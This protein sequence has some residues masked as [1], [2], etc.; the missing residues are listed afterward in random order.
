MKKNILLILFFVSVFSA[1]GQKLTTK[2][3]NILKTAALTVDNKN[4]NNRV[5]KWV[6]PI[7]YKI[8]GDTTL[9]YIRKQIDSSFSQLQRLTHL[10]I[11]KTDDDDDANFLIGIGAD[12]N[13]SGIFS[14]QL[15]HYVNQYG[16]NHYNVNAKSEIIRAETVVLPDSYDD[17]MLTRASLLKNI[18]KLLGLFTP[19]DE[20]AYSIF[21]SQTNYKVKIDKSDG[22]II[23]AFYDPQFMAG[24]DASHVINAIDSL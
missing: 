5:I 20:D 22:K 11:A 17:K 3:K 1:F 14:D 4:G 13:T 6:T 8:Y 7:R 10:D 18:V 12:A 9:E 21:Y 2:E 24:M 23:G 19:S 16:G 15:L